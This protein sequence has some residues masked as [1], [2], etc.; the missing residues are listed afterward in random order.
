[1]PI[2]IQKLLCHPTGSKRDHTLDAQLLKE[3]LDTGLVTFQQ[4][5]EVYDDAPIWVQWFEGNASKKDATDILTQVLPKVAGF[6]WTANVSNT[7]TSGSALDLIGEDLSAENLNAIL[8]S[9][10]DTEFDQLK[11]APLTNAQNF[12]LKKMAYNKREDLFEILVKNGWDINVQNDQG[13]SLL[14]NCSDWKQAQIVLS[15]NP[16]VEVIDQAGTTILDCVQ[17]W[18]YGEDF[19][20]I[21]KDVSLHRAHVPSSD[22]EKAKEKLFEIIARQKIADLKKNLKSL[23]EFPIS[24]PLEDSHNRSPLFL[25]CKNLRVSRRQSA[26]N[27]YSRFFIRFLNAFIP[28]V[29]KHPHFGK[30]KLLKTVEGWS[31]FDHTMMV[32]LVNTTRVHSWFPRNLISEDLKS[33]IDQ[34]STQRLPQLQSSLDTWI[35][36]YLNEYLLSSS[37]KD[38]ATANRNA[39]LIFCAILVERDRTKA[40]DLLFE[41][42]SHL[43]ET[44]HTFSQLLT[45]WIQEG[46]ALKNSFNR[47]AFSSQGIGSFACLWALK[48]NVIQGSAIEKALV[49]F[50][51]EYISTMTS[52]YSTSLADPNSPILEF[53]ETKLQD[54]VKNYPQL[55]DQCL[56]NIKEDKNN[57]DPYLILQE[58]HLILTEFDERLSAALEKIVL[59]TK[60]A[61]ELQSGKVCQ[62]KM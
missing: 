28:E 18:S 33:D 17:K 3:F 13:T 10:T 37:Y 56:E 50:S 59:S 55:L 45:D 46:S 5:M 23:S 58:P 30:D 35:K 31:E 53:I 54:C 21:L 1:M 26:Q 29:K 25:M 6:V 36:E 60:V 24:G 12:G 42:L 52:R 9:L 7:P 41:Q 27:A 14:M 49:S 22:F 2:N 8:S 11:H 61:D 51:F 15:H 39:S 4:L 47:T 40:Q 38:S 20:K 32:L 62:R 44:S 57:Q 16:N 48:N 19:E 34:W 43:G